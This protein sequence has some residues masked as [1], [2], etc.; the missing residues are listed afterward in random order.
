MP[1]KIDYLNT[2]PG[3]R[4]GCDGCFEG[5]KQKIS[6]VMEGRVRTVGG[7]HRGKVSDF[8]GQ[9]SIAIES[10][11]EAEGGWYSCAKR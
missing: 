4:Y 3:R 11:C 9:N 8:V 10:Y 2:L 7:A 5:K 1:Y 6:E